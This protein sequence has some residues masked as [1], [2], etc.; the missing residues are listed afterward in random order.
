MDKLTT[1]QPD[2]WKNLEAVLKP[3]INQGSIN[4][5]QSEICQDINEGVAILTTNVSNLIGSN[6]GLDIMN[7]NKHLKLFKLLE[8]TDTDVTIYDDS[9]NAQYIATNEKIR[10]YLPK[11]KEELSPAENKPDYTGLDQ[12]GETITLDKANKKEIE[13]IIKSD[14]E[15]DSVNL[16]IKDDQ[17]MGFEVNETGVYLFPGYTHETNLSTQTADKVLK[18]YAFMIILGEEFEINLGKYQNEDRY[19]LITGIATGVTT[20]T[21]NEEVDEDG[22]INENDWSL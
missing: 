10:I 11:H 4:I 21:L 17:L 19:L 13:T 22:T 9:N 18:S 20:L 2:Q 16:L 15:A 14:T 7:P 3:L 12:I 1:I 8:S 6:I 5:R